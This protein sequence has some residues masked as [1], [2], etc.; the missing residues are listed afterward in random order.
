SLLQ[1]L[2]RPAAEQ[3]AVAHELESVRAQRDTAMTSADGTVQVRYGRDGR[4]YPFRKEG[5]R[6]MPAGPSDE[7]PAAAWADAA[8]TDPVDA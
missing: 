3:L 6:W 5:G 1:R 8:A 4:W 2:E 7:D